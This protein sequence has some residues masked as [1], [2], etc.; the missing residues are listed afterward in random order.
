[1]KGAGALSRFGNRRSGLSAFR[2]KYERS[3][4]R[5]HSVERVAVH[6]P[7]RSSIGRDIDLSGFYGT[8]PFVQ[9]PLVVRF[10]RREVEQLHGLADQVERT[11]D[12]HKGVLGRFLQRFTQ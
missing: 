7:V 12:G 11:A 6:G 10:R 1:M 5:I 8:T 9:A 3:G 4:L 2:A